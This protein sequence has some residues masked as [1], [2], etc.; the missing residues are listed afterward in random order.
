MIMQYIKHG[1]LFTALCLLLSMVCVVTPELSSGETVG[2]WVWFGEVLPFTVG[3]VIVVCLLQLYE[4]APLKEILFSANF[5]IYLSWCL[6]FL[7]IVETLWGMGQLYGFITSGHSHFAITGSFFNPGPYA[8]YLA[9]L[10]PICLYHYRRVPD[11]WKFL[12]KSLKTERAIAMITGILIL[13]VLPSTMSRSAWVAA[14]LSC[15]W[16]VYM[17][18]DKRKWSILWQRY[19]KRY[20]LCGVGIFLVLLLAI[21]G[22]FFLKLDSALGRLFMWKITCRAIATNPWGCDTG[23]AFAYGEAQSSYFALGDYAAWEERVAG[24]PE[25]AFNEYLEFA[26]RYGIAMCILAL[27]VIL[28]CLWMGMKLHRYGIC[29]ALI[30]LLIFSFSSYPLHLPA[31]II[32][33][34]FL[35]LACGIGDVTSKYLVLCVWLVVWTGGYTEKWVQERNACHDWM[36]ARILYRSGAYGAANRAYKKLYP[37]LKKKGTFLFE[38]GHSLHM[39]GRYDESFDCLEQ[40]RL[41]SNDPMILNIMGKD[42]QALHKYE[43]AETFFLISVNRLPSRIYPYYL[44]AKLYS[45]PDY[46]DEDRFRDMEWNVLNRKPKVYSIAI[47]E[48]RKEVKEI[49]RA[50]DTRNCTIRF[51]NDIELEE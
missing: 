28:G 25:Y 17:H 29:G 21:I 22:M 30:S 26:L 11:K 8:G 39:S 35:L 33:G 6:I 9:M 12:R 10:L 14:V 31:F 5:F 40:A 37:I 27:F 50:W 48:M 36:N 20:V 43:C 38:Y 3:C 51:S 7:G 16:V 32:T 1:L 49:A 13:C 41:Y 34:I 44:L 19:K 24:S 18:R 4:K 15:I 45:E 2:R 47:E 42:C 23:F 46:R